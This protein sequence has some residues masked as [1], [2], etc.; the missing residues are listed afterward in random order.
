MQSQDDVEVHVIPSYERLERDFRISSGVILPAGEEYTFT[1][2]RFQVRTANRR[3]LA[4]TSSVELGSFFSGDR[5]EVVVNLAVRPRPGVRV[6]LE[7]EWNRL[8]L[9]EGRFETRLFRVIADTQF[10]PWISLVNNI[11]FDS[12]SDVLG[13]QF[14]LRWILEPGNDLFVVYTQNWRDD[15]LMDRFVTQDRRGAA[16][17]VYTYRF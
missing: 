9:P 12:V 13:W 8:D 5:Q 10:G 14:R 15:A 7:N 11:Q 3:V 1:R 17:F 16:K 2:Y 4:T 6:N